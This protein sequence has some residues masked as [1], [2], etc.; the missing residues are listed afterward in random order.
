MRLLYNGKGYQTESSYEEKDIPKS[1]G[2]RWDPNA[3]V[4]WTD[5][6][7]K[8][9][10]LLKYA[11][12]DTAVILEKWAESRI[13]AIERS[14]AITSSADIPSPSGLTYFPFQKAGIEFAKNKNIVLIA[15]EMGLG[16]TIQAIGIMNADDDA[17]KILIIC[18]ATLKINW[19]N[20]ILKWSVVDRNVKIANG[21][22]FPKA[23]VVIVN[24]DI[25]RK[26]S[27]D[28]K[29]TEWDLLIVDE[30][31]YL[32]NSQA[33]RTQEVFGHRNFKTHTEIH[34]IV[35][36]KSVF[37]TGTPILN[38][39]IELWPLMKYSGVFR[40]WRQYVI[41]YCKGYIGRYGWD[42]SGASN[43]EE[44]Q[45]ILRSK[46]MVRRLKREVLTELPPKRR[47]VI[48]LPINGCK[49]AI[50]EENRVWNDQQARLQKLQIVVELAKASD[51]QEEY[52]EAIK[53]LRKGQMVAFTEMA[54]VRHQTA[55]AKLPYVIDH[56][57]NI[58]DQ[59]DKL[60][61]FAHHHDVI[62]A[63]M[64]E[65]KDIAVELTGNTKVNDRQ[66]LVHK[67]QTDPDCKLFVGSITAAGLG[68]T[69]TAANNVVF[70]EI[71]WVPANITQAEDRTHRIGQVNSVLVQH[72]VLEG[73]LDSVM[74]QRVIEKQNVIDA[75][76]DREVKN[77][78]PTVIP[79]ATSD[80]TR[81]KVVKEA[82]EI[83]AEEITEIHNKLRFLSARCDGAI[84]IDGMGFNK[85][86]SPIGKSLAGQNTLTAKQAILG[87]RL[88]KKYRG[89]LGE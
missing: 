21:Q 58:L 1:A 19:K 70:A 22:E 6:E 43:L 78:L 40:N 41:R 81:E 85:F 86:D 35:A 46:I 38:R 18:P 48:E 24:Y 66:D 12:H 71:D 26:Y 36:K 73:S 29:N 10:R 8:A 75:A 45:N 31:H 2:F 83:I 15:D 3:K 77:I 68:I 74:A 9:Y 60:V 50:D 47:Q 57:K 82:E 64:N 44:L 27:T 65:F 30:S 37:L 28:I 67:F 79:I 23:D 33:Q 20:E 80:L 88:I 89:Q 76:L 61:V 32:K 63:I 34:P 25:L 53:Q 11:E 17:K 14:K 49:E 55:V 84:Q 4:W 62:D 16:K 7:E 51:N 54:K 52:E 56:I 39:P 59:E 72:L 42:I 87:R 13:E 5:D 69:L